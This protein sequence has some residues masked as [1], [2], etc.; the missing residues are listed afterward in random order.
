MTE[1]D[2]KFI[3][4]DTHFY[5]PDDCF[6]RHI[7]PAFRDKV[8]HLVPTEDPNLSQWALGDKL[9]VGTPNNLADAVPAPGAFEEMFAG[10]ASPEQT[11][12]IRPRDVPALMM[13]EAR[14]PLMDEQG[15]QAQIM[16]P[17][18]GLAVEHDFENDVPA[19]CAN[20][21]AFNRWLEDDWGYGGD[22]RI[23]SVPM[24]TTLD[25]E[26]A[27]K[28]TIRVVELGSPFIYVKTGPVGGKSPADPYF[29]RFWKTVE[30]TGVKVIFHIDFT[31]FNHMYASHWSEDPVRS[32]FQY[33][34][35]QM[36]YSLIERPIMDTMA[37]LL[38][39]NLFGRFPKVQVLSIEWGSAWIRPLMRLADKAAKMGAKGGS[40]LG[41]PLKDLPSE[42]LANHLTVA[43]YFEEDMIELK[44]TI[45]V[46]R[47]LF[48]SDYPHPE[49]LRV[50]RHFLN[51]LKGYSDDEIRMVM[52]DNA[53]KLLGLPVLAPV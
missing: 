4:S 24:I 28:E 35:L 19:L 53:A 22:G 1:I 42:T 18:V 7:E 15:I 5:E 52:H 29:D 49:G 32:V 2:Y 30:D 31:D 51:G 3:D 26:W 46:D 37:A 48:G 20:Y 25:V 44:E 23:W 17:T 27:V 50:P 36:Y 16:L 41:G 45:G 10:K 9:V 34:P 8:I 40:W 47:I 14:Y 6:S 12:L 11:E 21:R 39:H 43:P 33:S 38:L 13:R